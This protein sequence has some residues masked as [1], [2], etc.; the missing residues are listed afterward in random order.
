MGNKEE[1]YALHFKPMFSR[2]HMHM[3]SHVALFR[4]DND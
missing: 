2:A 3:D 4:R 1:G